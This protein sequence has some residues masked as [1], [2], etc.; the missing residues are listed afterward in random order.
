LMIINGSVEFSQ[1]KKHGL[2]FSDNSLPYKGLLHNSFTRL[3]YD[4]IKG[5]V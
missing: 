3:Y 5:N 1:K 2:K 4:I